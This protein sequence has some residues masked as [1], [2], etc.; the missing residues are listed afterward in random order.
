MP[1]NTEILEKLRT[2][3][4]SYI[5]LLEKHVALWEENDRLRKENKELRAK[6]DST[7]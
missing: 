4:E 2:I 7:S 6:Q 3:E 5:H 1:E